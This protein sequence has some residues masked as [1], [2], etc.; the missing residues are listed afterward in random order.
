MKQIKSMLFSK[1]TSKLGNLFVAENSSKNMKLIH[2]LKMIG[3]VSAFSIIGCGPGNTG[4]VIGVQ[5]RRVW[6]HPT[7]FGMV[8]VPTGSFNTGQS[9]EDIFH[10][11]LAPNKQMTIA[12]FWMDETE[13]T[14]NEYRQFV[15]Y[16]IDSIAIEMLDND[17]YFIED[18]ETGERFINWREVR[19]SF[20]IDNPEIRDDVQDMYVAEDERFRHKKEIDTRK[21]FYSYEWID[22]HDAATN[23]E[24]LD[25]YNPAP[26]KKFI[27]KERTLI[28][29]DTLCFI[30]DFTYSY[31]E[32]MARHYFHHVKYDD[33]PVVGVN[34]HMA[35]AFSYWR[36]YYKEDYWNSLGAPPTEDYRLPT[37]YEWEYA[38]RGGRIG[39]KYPW[40]GP[41]TRN[42]KGCMLANFKPLRGNYGADG[43]LYPVRADSY[44]PN[45]YGLYN[46]AG[47]VSEWTRNAFEISSNIFTHDLNGDYRISIPEYVQQNGK[48]TREGSDITLKRKVIR[49]GSWKDIAYF[50]E[51]GAR[52]YEY[53]DSCRSFIGFRNVQS[54]IGRSNRDS[55]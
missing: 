54:Y 17:L 37:E 9:D 4:D 23:A 7:P 52:T 15:Q 45:D 46:M 42:S 51:N 43:G 50:I 21:L 33:Y 27:R 38:A 29:P 36:T 5:G 28:Y 11:Y 19:R 49:G 2:S 20:Y 24:N 6:F 55:K 44:F 53:Q 18:E 25:R 3:L 10:S 32:P 34:W 31:N 48:F 47:N 41:Y 40:G 22:Y 8:Y 16:V 26:R 13:I 30:R 12:G 35:N 1:W 14:N 39:N